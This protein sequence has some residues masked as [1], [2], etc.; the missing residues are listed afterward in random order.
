[1]AST[2]VY[3]C[4]G[5]TLF[6]FSSGSPPKTCAVVRIFGALELLEFDGKIGVPVKPKI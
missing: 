1:M 5:L 6:P 2:M 3:A 4:S